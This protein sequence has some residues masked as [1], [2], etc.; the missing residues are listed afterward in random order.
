[1]YARTQ[2]KEVGE[3]VASACS[4]STRH[5]SAGSASHKP[6]EGDNKPQAT[7]CGVPFK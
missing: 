7:R 4:G 2:I 5:L 1:M 3:S 6:G